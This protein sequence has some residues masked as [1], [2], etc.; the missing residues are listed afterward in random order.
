MTTSMPG[1]V[2][3]IPTHSAG[4]VITAADINQLGAGLRA[5]E[6][7][8]AGAQRTNVL[9][10][11]AV[12]DAVAD[13]TAAIR[14]T[15]TAAGV[16]GLVQF[17]APPVAYHVTG[18]LVPL[19][20]QTWQGDPGAT[21]RY[22]ATGAGFSSG[23]L[24][25]HTDGTVWRD[26]TDVRLRG[27][28]FE[29]TDRSFAAAAGVGIGWSDHLPARITI[30]DCQASWCSLQVNGGSH[31]RLVGNW[32]HDAPGDRGLGTAGNLGMG[33]DGRI[34]HNL[35]ENCRGMGIYGGTHGA[36]I[37][38]NVVVGCGLRWPGGVA[39]GIDCGNAQNLLVADNLVWGCQAGILSENG[40]LG[41]L[42]I[43]VTAGG[44]GY[45]EASPPAVTIAAGA[46][47]TA[48]ARAHV[49]SGA[50]VAIEVTDPGQGYT[51][52]PAVTIAAGGATAV[53]VLGSTVTI[54]NNVV[55]GATVAQGN[56]IQVW[57]S[58]P[59][60]GPDNAVIAGNTVRHHNVG[61]YVQDIARAAIRGNDVRQVG[62]D[63]VVAQRTGGAFT[64]LDIDDNTVLGPDQRAGT[65]GACLLVASS[66]ARIRRN[67]FDGEGCVTG[68][69]IRGLVAGTLVW[70]NAFSGTFGG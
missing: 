55:I 63:G 25:C 20:G 2:D 26:L 48:T 18:T 41:V 14:A 29:N 49:A 10:F 67:H 46:T 21:L 30:E 9:A 8:V 62:Q 23:M 65:Y 53:A 40:G 38:G 4:Q 34:S 6:A 15:I 54:R 64:L 33:L 69:A 42:R 16:G 12:G 31:H 43:E 28:R 37:D 24:V 57:A 59:G 35:V 3:T 66:V 32:V 22:D 13:D 44:S 5:T 47:T 17:P 58:T 61:I 50:V 36:V 7:I 56:G 60:P 51:T 27:L 68:R 52:V 19:S 45:S 70:D 39:F 11:G 1:V